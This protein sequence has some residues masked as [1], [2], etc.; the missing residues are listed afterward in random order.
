MDIAV[1]ELE[2]EGRLIHGETHREVVFGRSLQIRDN[3]VSVEKEVRTG[4]ESHEWMQ[5]RVSSH[6]ARDPLNFRRTDKEAHTC[7][8]PQ[9]RRS[10]RGAEIAVHGPLQ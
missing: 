9:Q 4:S 8:I 1:P 3:P 7:Y 10:A 6:S 2:V 5:R